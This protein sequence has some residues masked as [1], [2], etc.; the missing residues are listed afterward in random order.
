MSG[1]AT[2]AEDQV[3]GLLDVLRRDGFGFEPVGSRGAYRLSPPPELVFLVDPVL[4]ALPDVVAEYLDDMADGSADAFDLTCIHLV[5]DL[6]TDFGAAGNRIR[7]LGFR[8]HGGRAEYFV[9]RL[10]DR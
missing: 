8:R 7:S 5:E 10:P 1:A 4:V 3:R 9:D 2:G 6:G